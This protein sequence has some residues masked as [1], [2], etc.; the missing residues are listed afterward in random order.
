MKKNER[1][2]RQKMQV[3]KIPQWNDNRLQGKGLSRIKGGIGKKVQVGIILQCNGHRLQRSLY[4]YRTRLKYK[5]SFKNKRKL[6][7][8]RFHGVNDAEII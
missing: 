1:G 2:R 5:H 7:V 8:K 4:N 3:G 6:N